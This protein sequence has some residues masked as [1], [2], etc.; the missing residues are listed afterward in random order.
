MDSPSSFRFGLLRSILGPKVGGARVVP[1]VTKIVLLF[2]VFI[3]VS[4]IASNY[5]NL[6]MNKGE[7]VGLTDRLLVKDLSELYGFAATQG[8][9]LGFNGNL[10]EAV[11]AIQRS[12]SKNLTMDHSVA[13]GVRRDGSLLFWASKQAAPQS[14]LDKEARD[15]LASDAEGEGKLDFSIG[16]SRYFG[17]FKYNNQWKAFIVRAEETKEFQAQ[18]NSIFLRIVGMILAM[19]LVI[20][21]VGA[22]LVRR[23][24]RYV[25]RIT[26]SIMGMQKDQKMALI[27]FAGAPN[28]E[29][30]YLG[31]SLNS[32]SSIIDN[33]MRIFRRFV[34]R[35]IAQRAFD[36]REIRLEGSTKDLT[37]LFTD[38]KGFT[39]I[40]E[41]L[42]MDVIDVL[43][44]HYQRAIGQIH[45]EDGI[46]G[47]IIGDALLAVFGTL[48][49]SSEKSL[50]ALRAGFLV[51]QVAADLRE[52]MGALREEIIGR[53]GALT[54]ED[55]AVYQ[56]VLLE[57]GVGIDGGDVYYGNIGS[58]ERM[59]TTVIGDNVNSASRL[60]SLTRIY[61]VPIICSELV[62]DEAELSSSDYR[63]LEL[64]TVLVKGKTRG[65]RIFWPLK[66]SDIG[67]K[68]AEELDAFS[69]GLASYYTGAWAQAG[70]AWRDLTL[71]FIAVFRDRIAGREAPSD[72]SG[73]WAMTAK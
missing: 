72:W 66:K 31:L 35:D 1:L 59:T 32:L 54:E 23:I 11:S 36:E 9:I 65:K 14:V 51:Q 52:S 6:E 34:T 48:S 29:I 67:P 15:K 30:S 41:T 17:V 18:T 64:D 63:F 2:S 13:F 16:G 56:A 58:Y 42:G 61:K 33:L 22:L 4:N 44:L 8:E 19:T 38:I 28:D 24:L 25:G 37:L 60:E 68:L 55:E 20:T 57:V 53:R 27:D 39:H 12:A 62:K 40:T 49:G 43:N 69:S 50:Q 26:Q 45:D 3:L 46:V 73:T 5:V 71:P 7:L 70:S 47:S 21:L 10:A